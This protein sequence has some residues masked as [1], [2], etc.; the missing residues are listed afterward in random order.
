M[1]LTKYLYIYFKTISPSLKLLVIYESEYYLL[2]LKAIM[3]GLI[4]SNDVIIDSQESK[5]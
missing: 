5:I 3:G 4:K 2:I 1:F